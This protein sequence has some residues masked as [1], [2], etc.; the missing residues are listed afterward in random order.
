VQ[1]YQQTKL[2]SNLPVFALYFFLPLVI[3]MTSVRATY[4]QFPANKL[5]INILPIQSTI[6]DSNNNTVPW[7]SAQVAQVLS[8]P[9]AAV[10]RDMGRDH[11]RPARSVN[12]TVGSEST[13]YRKV[14]LVPVGTN[15][16]YGTGNVGSAG[17]GSGTDY[18][19]GYISLGGQTYG[20]GNGIPTGVARLN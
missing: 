18:L 2:K 14:Q 3:K 10:L 13:I 4:S 17:P 16:Y 1:I 20:G 19:T 15:G 9:G 6:V 7:A 11:F 8:T 5:Y 12:T